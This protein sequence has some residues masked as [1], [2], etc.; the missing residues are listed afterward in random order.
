MPRD[1]RDLVPLPLKAMASQHE[2]LF[3][4]PNSGTRLMLFPRTSSPTSTK[5]HIGLSFKLQLKGGASRWPYLL[6]ILSD[7]S[8]A[9]PSS[10]DPTEPSWLPP[11][12]FLR[13]VV[14]ANKMAQ[15][16]LSK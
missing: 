14:L 9:H 7:L 10:Q 5:L 15:L 4:T 6:Y 16:V 3:N 12:G 13:A 8:F 2:L 1:P 11:K